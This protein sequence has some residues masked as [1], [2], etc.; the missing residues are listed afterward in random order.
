MLKHNCWER[1]DKK[2]QANNSS[3]EVTYLASALFLLD[4]TQ[5]H[6]RCWL[7]VVSLY[8]FFTK[9]PPKV[10]DLRIWVINWKQLTDFVQTWDRICSKSWQTKSVII[11]II[12]TFC[13]FTSFQYETLAIAKWKDYWATM[14]VN[15]FSK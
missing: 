4:F 9:N 14:A 11:V 13:N 1:S 2:S 5:T 7:N 6:V 15:H 8:N 10:V 3:I 12:L